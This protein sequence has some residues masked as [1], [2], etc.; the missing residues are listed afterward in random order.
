VATS[1]EALE[2]MP[3]VLHGDAIPC[4]P[5]IDRKGNLE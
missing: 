4:L 5:V 3:A 1:S 2:I